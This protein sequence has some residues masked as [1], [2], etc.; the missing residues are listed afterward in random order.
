[1]ALRVRHVNIG[2]PRKLIILDGVKGFFERIN[3]R[4]FSGV[5]LPVPFG[6]RPVP[7]ETCSSTRLL[8]IALMCRFGAKGYLMA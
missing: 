5:K 6:K 2:K 8:T 7:G 1:M 4:L 3:I